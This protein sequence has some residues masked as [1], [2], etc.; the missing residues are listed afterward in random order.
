MHSVRSDGLRG[1]RGGSGDPPVRSGHQRQMK[2]LF[3]EG[4]VRRLG[5][6]DHNV[7]RVFPLDAVLNLPSDNYSHGLR[8]QVA[9]AKGSF[10]EADEAI[11][12][13]TGSPDI[14]C[15]ATTLNKLPPPTRSGAQAY[16]DPGEVEPL[17]PLNLGA[18][19]RT[20]TATPSPS[21]SPVYHADVGPQARRVPPFPASCRRSPL[22]ARPGSG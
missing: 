12:L 17:M 16:L 22:H 21:P 9:V 15:P 6:R 5:Y 20:A 13:N 1:G 18:Y 10:Y 7:S 11:A 2:T 4:Q 14:L 3:G 8:E 19:L